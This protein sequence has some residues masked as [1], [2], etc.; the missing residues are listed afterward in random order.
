MIYLYDQ[1]DH[2]GPIW[3][4]NNKFEYKH[5]NKSNEKMTTLLFFKIRTNQDQ[6]PPDEDAKSL[7]LLGLASLED[8]EDGIG[9]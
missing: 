6:V 7:Q 3:K 5:N 8:Q 2:W 9:W 4:I 1:F